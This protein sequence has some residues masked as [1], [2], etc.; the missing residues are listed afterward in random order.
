MSVVYRQTVWGN[1]CQTDITSVCVTISRL[2]TRHTESCH[3]SQRRRSSTNVK[4]RD[5]RFLLLQLDHLRQI[6]RGTCTTS[7]TRRMAS[8][9]KRPQSIEERATVKLTSSHSSSVQGTAHVMFQVKMK[10]RDY[11]KGSTSRRSFCHKATETHKKKTIE[12][13]QT[14]E[15]TDREG[16]LSWTTKL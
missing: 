11:S 2:T 1:S 7:K 5:Q 12:C 8:F 9:G 10:R 13:K 16:L 3:D 14:P 4:H 6:Y 15:C